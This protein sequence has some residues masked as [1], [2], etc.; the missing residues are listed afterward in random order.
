VVYILL[1]V[2]L[3]LLWEGYDP[4]RDTQSELG[5]VN[6]PYRWVM[7]VAGFGGLGL[8]ILAFAASYALVLRGGWPQAVA[9]IFLGVAGLGMVIVGSSPATP[10]VSMSPPRAACMAC[11]ARPAPSACPPLRSPPHGCSTATAASAPVGRSCRCWSGSSPSPPGPSSRPAS[12][13][14]PPACSNVLACGRRCGDDRGVPATAH[15]EP[16]RATA[17]KRQRLAENP[18]E[19]RRP[20][21]GPPRHTGCGVSAVLADADECW[22]SGVAGA[23]LSTE[24]RPRAN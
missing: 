2:V 1:T 9:V 8:S 15:P 12:S 20:P 3:G 18:P 6:S 16:T 13:P 14:T 11:S 23:Q 5:A 10:A 7:N 22:T 17:C 4:I 21:C 19:E 24:T